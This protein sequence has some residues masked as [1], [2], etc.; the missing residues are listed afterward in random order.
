MKKHSSFNTFG[1]NYKTKN[2]MILGGQTKLDSMIVEENKEEDD[3][4]E[5]ENV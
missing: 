5:I 1:S 3:E 4:D 2:K